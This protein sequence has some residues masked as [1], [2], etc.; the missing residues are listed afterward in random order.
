M[1]PKDLKS[2]FKWADRHPTMH[3]G[4]LFVPEYYS[5]HHK[6]HFPCWEDPVLFNKSAPV[7]I[8]YCSGNGHWIIEKAKISPDTHWVAVEKKF[9]RVRKIWSKAQNEKIKNLLIVCGEADPFNAYY[10]IEHEVDGV[11]VNFPDPWPKPKHAKH[12]LIQSPFVQQISRIVKPKGKAILVTDDFPY[13]E[14]MIQEMRKE[15]LWK[16]VYP[17]PYYVTQWDNYGASYFDTLWREKGKTIY[18]LQ[19]ENCK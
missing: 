11:F 14:Q 2:P 13:V 8:E 12:R 4:V 9:E 7:F 17:S 3:Q 1:K 5:E 18:Y 6:W 16:S 10:L 19:F 15:G